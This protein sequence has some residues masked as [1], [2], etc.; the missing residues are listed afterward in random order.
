M[1]IKSFED[2]EIYKISIDLTKDIY[3]LS[4]NFPVEERYGMTD[5]IK[6]AVASIGANI[7][8]GFGRF[9]Y[10]DRMVFM[11]HARGSLYETRHFLNL[12][13]E[14]GYIDKLTKEK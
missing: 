2:L 7:A 12:A 13:Y 1:V 11:F 3:G 8:E 5:Q 14:V 4:N 10:K 6:R 9:S